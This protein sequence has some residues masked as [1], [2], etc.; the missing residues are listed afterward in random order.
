MTDCSTQF[1]AGSGGLV[2]TSAILLYREG[3]ARPSQGGP[4]FSSIHDIEQHE[5]GPVIAAFWVWDRQAGPFGGGS[6]R[7]TRPLP[8]TH[9][10]A[11]GWNTGTSTPCRR[12]RIGW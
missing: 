7:V 3:Y 2:L 11:T 5:S 4:A 9:A 8:L 6:T 12:S 10:P 1:E